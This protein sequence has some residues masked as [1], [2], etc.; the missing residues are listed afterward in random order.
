MSIKIHH[1]A[2]SEELKKLDNQC[3]IDNSP[4]PTRPTIHLIISRKGGG[5]TSLLLNMLSNKSM[6]GRKADNIFLISPT[7]MNDKKMDSLLGEL[8]PENKYFDS[9]TDNNLHTI[10]DTIKDFNH[11]FKK[12]REPW[13]I[14]IFDD[15]LAEISRR[16]NKAEFL[17][18]IVTTCRHLKSSLIFLVQKT[19]IPPIIRANADLITIFKIANKQERDDALKEFSIPEHIYNVATDEPFSFLHVSYCK[20]EPLYFKRFSPIEIS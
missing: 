19:R 2:L 12:K 15:L 6:Y 1:S 3:P 18:K 20:G 10:V 11:N 8:I 14:I 4:L 16:G 17:N 9:L 13:N 5:K 7:A